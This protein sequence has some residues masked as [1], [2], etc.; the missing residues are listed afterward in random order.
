MQHKQAPNKPA[1]QNIPQAKNLSTNS[2][3]DQKLLQIENKDNSLYL[4]DDESDSGNLAES[5]A[6]VNSLNHLVEDIC[7][8]LNCLIN[9]MSAQ[10]TNHVHNPQLFVPEANSTS[11]AGQ[12]N[13]NNIP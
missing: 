1:Q 4:T 2:P 12:G 10:C 11:A 9:D 7:T 6:R 8:E 13:N 3:I 5:I